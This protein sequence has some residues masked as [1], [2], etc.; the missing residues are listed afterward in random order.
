MPLGVE[1]RWGASGA[2]RVACERR[3]AWRQISRDPADHAVVT[4]K[5]IYAR[6]YPAPLKVRATHKTSAMMM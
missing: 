4:D 3:R 2:G 1:T 5:R 6:V